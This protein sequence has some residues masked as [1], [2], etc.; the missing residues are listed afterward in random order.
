M[1]GHFFGSEPSSEWLIEG[2]GG[3][4]A[5]VLASSPHATSPDA[6]GK[7]LRETTGPSE[8]E[9]PATAKMGWSLSENKANDQN[10]PH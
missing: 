9:S 7:Q 2:N 4:S 5:A 6:S 10:S 3:D 8:Q 1:T